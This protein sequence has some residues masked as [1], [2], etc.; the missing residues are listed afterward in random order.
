MTGIVVALAL[1]A[2]AGAAILLAGGRRLAGWEAVVAALLVGVAGYAWQGHPA[3]PGHPLAS[4]GAGRTAFDEHLIE[5]RKQ[6]GGRFG[7]AAKWLTLSDGLARQ[8]DTRSAANV[9]ASA[10]RNAPDDPDLWMGLGNALVAHEGG[11]LSPAAEY[12]YRQ[13]LKRDAR[14]LGA[15]YFYALALAQSGQLAPARAMWAEL[16]GEL[17]LGTP[18]RV[19]LERNLTLID[20][21]SAAE[22]GIGPGIGQ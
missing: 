13:A 3:L 14:S 9:L 4:R 20:R 8:G 1:A 18:F 10:V 15:R 22:A 21:M 11:L 16:A 5:R 7:E 17:P 19:E 6:L 2:I 12:A